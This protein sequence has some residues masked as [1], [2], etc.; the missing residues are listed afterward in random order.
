M[1]LTLDTRLSGLGRVFFA[2][3][4]YG[5]AALAWLALFGPTSISYVVVILGLA[6]SLSADFWRAGLS[7]IRQS[8]GICDDRARAALALL[9]LSL[10]TVA[11]GAWS[12]TPGA[13][14]DGFK[15][16]AFSFFGCVICFRM[17]IAPPHRVRDMSNLFAIA[18]LIAAVLLLFEGVS[19]GLLRRIV[20]P[21]DLSPGRWKDEIALAKG[22]T[23]ISPISFSAGAVLWALM[24]RRSLALAP[25]MITFLASFQFSVS[26]NVVAM[27]M[28]IAAGAAA[29]IRPKFVLT[30]IG[31]VFVA[32]SILAPL[33]VYLPVE[34]LVSD[35]GPGLP[36]SW[37]QR[38]VL[39][40]ASA[41]RVFESCG[42]IGC[43]ADS[44]RAW[45]RE[46]KLFDVEGASFQS[47]E[48]APH[49]HNIFVQIWVELGV[50]G[51]LAAAAAVVFGTRSLVSSDLSR[52]SAAAV[53]GAAAA[54]YASFSLA[55]SLWQG[56]HL[57]VLS[58][59]AL[60][61]ALS[62]KLMRTFRI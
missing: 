22:I 27:V 10:W 24:R 49:P 37:A 61:V 52:I 18:V 34:R 15:I 58:L 11:G 42:L 53:A 39:W 48:A 8:K 7:R 9:A 47:V 23:L 38:V 44:T 21:A 35:Q 3:F 33:L 20:P 43:G 59:A 28:G 4:P 51:A 6:A 45:T 50:I 12:P 41:E 30:A 56:W 31:A 57:A 2:L 36:A 55:A 32:S 40:Q 16:L 60:G 17:L 25:V 13:F 1:R 14:E 54:V 29:M 5:M 46:A 62:Q 26:A 19:N